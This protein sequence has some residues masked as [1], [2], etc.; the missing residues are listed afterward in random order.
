MNSALHR[1]NSSQT[2]LS[3]STQPL[4]NLIRLE[5]LPKRI[6]KPID[7]SLMLLLTRR[8]ASVLNK[9]GFKPSVERASCRSITTTIRHHATHHHSLYSLLFKYLA[10]VSVDE[11]IVGVL[12]DDGIFV[13]G[14]EG[15]DVGHQLPVDG[16][17][18]D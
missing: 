2:S 5:H 6:S 17:F 14:G 10:E 3:S 9:P 12:V 13:F 7:P 1:G 18:G 4:T 8:P 16:A 15:R 11:G